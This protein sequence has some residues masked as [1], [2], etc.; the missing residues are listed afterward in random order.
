MNCDNERNYI[1][2]IKDYWTEIKILPND[3]TWC[4]LM[5]WNFQWEN[6]KLFMKSR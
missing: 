3:A 6:R 2:I 1:I 4:G 5:E